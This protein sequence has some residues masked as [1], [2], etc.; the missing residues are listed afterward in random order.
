LAVVATRRAT[1][2]THRRIRT[3]AFTGK[4]FQAACKRLHIACRIACYTQL[5]NVAR[6]LII[7]QEKHGCN[8][9]KK[10]LAIA[11]NKTLDI[12]LQLTNISQLIKAVGDGSI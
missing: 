4:D 9:G 2:A 11:C 5:V 3:T 7:V 1:T 8:N 6:K 12:M 10:R